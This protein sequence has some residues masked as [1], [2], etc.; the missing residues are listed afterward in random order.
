MLCLT[1]Y[2]CFR[3]IKSEKTD[4]I[5]KPTASGFVPFASFPFAIT[6]CSLAVAKYSMPSSL[7]FFPV[8]DAEF[9]ILFLWE[10]KY[11]SQKVNVV[12]IIQKLV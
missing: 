11:F 5:S 7:H 8:W 3:R 2:V 4:V 12:E 1:S 6:Y 9:P 10:V